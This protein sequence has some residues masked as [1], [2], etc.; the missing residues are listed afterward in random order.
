[1]I[2]AEVG[3]F[4][5]AS[6]QSVR[7]IFTHAQFIVLLQSTGG[8]M[9]YGVDCVGEFWRM[10]V[11]LVENTSVSGTSSGDDDV[12][13]EKLLEV[14]FDWTWKWWKGCTWRMNNQSG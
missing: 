12:L 10:L 5:A 2:V 11:L 14:P 7:S 4:M 3:Y 6:F 13:G 8:G 1:M 9:E